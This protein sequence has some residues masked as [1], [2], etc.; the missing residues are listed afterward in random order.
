M[1]AWADLVFLLG[2]GLAV[3]GVLLLSVPAG[4]IVAGAALAATALLAERPA[5][6]DGS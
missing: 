4:L 6:S 2:L 3:V 5:R 1:P